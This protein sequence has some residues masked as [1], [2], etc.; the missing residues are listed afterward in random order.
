MVINDPETTH[1]GLKTTN[2][3][4]LANSHCKQ[5]KAMLTLRDSKLYPYWKV[6]FP[7]R[8]KLQDGLV[9]VSTL[10]IEQTIFLHS[11]QMVSTDLSMLQHCLIPL[12][13]PPS[14][15]TLCGSISKQ[16]ATPDEA[17]KLEVVLQ[18]CL[19]LV[20]HCDNLTWKERKQTSLRLL[21][22]LPWQLTCIGGSR[23]LQGLKLATTAAIFLGH[24]LQ[25]NLTD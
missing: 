17:I 11:T 21:E 5:E 4:F 1:T 12:S 22:Y 10:S 20:P 13:W 3:Y 8:A 23:L 2:L 14:H 15:S 18:D 19:L 16:G 7:D 24:I 9:L 25:G 6:L